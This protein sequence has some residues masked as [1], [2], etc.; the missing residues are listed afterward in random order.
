MS[1]LAR[2]RF[3]RSPLPPDLQHI[4]RQYSNITPEYQHLECKWTFAAKAVR[5][6]ASER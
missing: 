3:K 2:D 5:A 1:A 6:S 4:E